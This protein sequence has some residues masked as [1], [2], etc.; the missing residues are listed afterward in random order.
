MRSCSK[1]KSTSK[2]PLNI[3]KHSRSTYQLDK[4]TGGDEGKGIH[5][6]NN[7]KHL[8]SSSRSKSPREQYYKGNGKEKNT[9]ELEPF[10]TVEV[11]LDHN[12]KK[13]T[14]RNEM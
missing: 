14:Y 6:Q 11:C 5:I 3:R 4:Y 1:G 12:R 8:K 2:S 10:K 9:S 7:R 13:K